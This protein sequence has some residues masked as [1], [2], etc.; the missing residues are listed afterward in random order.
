MNRNFFT[1]MILAG[2][3]MAA[4]V[5]AQ[6]AAPPETALQTPAS[7]M[8]ATAPQPQAVSNSGPSS[9]GDPCP[10]PQGALQNSPDDLAKVQE[11]I[12]RFTLCVQRA[13]LL[14]R[15]NESAMKNQESTDSALGYAPIP[16][17]A[18]RG[19]MPGIPGAQS[20]PAGLAPLPAAALAGMDV[21]PVAAATAA[22]D[23]A[24]KAA[25]AAEVAETVAKEEASVSAS[26][27]IRE[28]F[29]SGDEVQA[30]LISPEGDEV[31]ARN[32]MKLPDGK[33][34]VVRITPAGVTVRTGTGAKT[35]EW[36]KS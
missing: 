16:A 5:S 26:W 20:G 28:I 33:T 14:E 23:A 2:L 13:Q 7:A 6:E 35:L 8:P 22:S 17:G 19:M 9:S 15:L 32:G 31:K 29:G 36:A 4:P 27:T 11:E 24:D 30:R 34:T 21:S 3:L 18:G 25:A 10:A 12:D 1:S